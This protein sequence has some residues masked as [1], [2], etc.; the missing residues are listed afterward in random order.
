MLKP[1]WWTLFQ[2]GLLL[3]R[4]DT[5]DPTISRGVRLLDIIAHSLDVSVEGDE[6]DE[7]LLEDIIFVT[8]S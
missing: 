1:S 6:H 4:E 8:D 3:R 7:E 5:E 2:L